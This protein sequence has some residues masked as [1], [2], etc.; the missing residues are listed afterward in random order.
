MPTF[1]S[2]HALYAQHLNASDLEQMQ[3]SA[4]PHFLNAVQQMWLMQSCCR[5]EAMVEFVKESGQFDDLVASLEDAKPD[6]LRACLDNNIKIVQ[7]NREIFYFSWDALDTIEVR[8]SQDAAIDFMAALKRLDI[9][10]TQ[11]RYHPILEAPVALDSPEGQSLADHNNFIDSFIIGTA[12][13]QADGY[14]LQGRFAEIAAEAGNEKALAAFT[15]REYSA[16]YGDF[17]NYDFAPS[18][19][20]ISAIED[21]ARIACDDYS[22]DLAPYSRPVSQ[23][24]AIKPELADALRNLGQNVVPL[25][26]MHIWGRTNA[27]IELETDSV[28]QA[29]FLNHFPQ[30]LGDFIE[31]HMPQ[32]AKRI[33][34]ELTACATARDGHNASPS[35]DA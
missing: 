13:R 32:T 2:H 8:S 21:A 3:T 26:D 5:A 24:W 20:N 10:L 1:A 14:F 30:E 34:D 23:Y 12:P 28:I 16:I 6:Y 11:W 33:Q 18:Y 7:G 9:D 4:H 19:Q 15:K 27:D 25:L 31:K 22:I 29:A 17:I 35:F